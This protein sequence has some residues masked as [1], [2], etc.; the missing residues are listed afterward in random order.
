MIKQGQQFTAV[1][2]NGNVCK[3]IDVKRFN[4]IKPW[5]LYTSLFH[6]FHREKKRDILEIIA[7]I[8]S[9]NIPKRT[10]SNIRFLKDIILQDEC[11]PIKKIT[12]KRQVDDFM[13]LNLTLWKY[14][15]FEFVFN[16]HRNCGYLK[17]KMVLFDIG[18]MMID[19][20][21]VLKK[22]RQKPWFKSLS[23]RFFLDKSIKPY[24][25]EQCNHFFNEAYLSLIWR[26]ECRQKSR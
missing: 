18:E 19:K 2:R 3:F 24:Y 22:M 9:S 14:G 20:E 4:L 10:F 8:K 25:E 7:A 17:K 5:T 13:Q 1:I 26:S 12:T 11:V 21:E 15:F 16:F 6:A 23:Y